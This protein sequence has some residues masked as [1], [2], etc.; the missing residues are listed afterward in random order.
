MW[1]NKNCEV[2][3]AIKTKQII[4]HLPSMFFKPMDQKDL[5][6]DILKHNKYPSNL[7]NIKMLI[8]QKKK[9]G[10]TLATSS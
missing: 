6:Y 1:P 10:F 9:G 7:A 4:F 5:K 2:S 3:K 8:T